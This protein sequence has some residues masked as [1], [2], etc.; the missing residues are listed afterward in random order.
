MRSIYWTKPTESGLGDRLLDILFMATYAKLHKSNLL[1]TW[2]VYRG[3][4]KQET[5]NLDPSFR[6]VDSQLENV[7]KYIRFPNFTVYT[8]F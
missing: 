4:E 6:Y 1:L 5:R 8:P 3:H 2:T 7:K